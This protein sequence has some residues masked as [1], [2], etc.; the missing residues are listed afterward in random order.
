MPR[1]RCC[2]RWCRPA[3]LERANGQLWSAELLTNALIGPALGALL[4]GL[5]LPLAF[6]LN[7]MAYGLAMLLVAGL[8]GQFQ[9]VRTDRR[10]WR[11]EIGEGFAFL[12]VGAFAADAGLDDGVLEPVPPDDRDWRWCCTRRKTWGFRLRPMG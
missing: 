7:A 6:G 9:A 8:A 11:A 10:G 3:R 2:P 5:W 1:R 4:I 12:R